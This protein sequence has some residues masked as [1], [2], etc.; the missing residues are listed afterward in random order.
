MYIEKFQRNL[1]K[2]IKN[3]MGN[4]LLINEGS[5]GSNT[6]IIYLKPEQE[7]SLERMEMIF[8]RIMKCLKI[9]FLFRIK[10]CYLINKSVMATF[11]NMQVK[12][13]NFF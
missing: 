10:F 3:Y 7:Q 6:G 5:L 8:N 9:Y 2:L 4:I 13:L 1:I 11:Q 12:F